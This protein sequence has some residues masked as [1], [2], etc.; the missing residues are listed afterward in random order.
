M[1]EELPLKR[2]KKIPPLPAIKL[3]SKR[4]GSHQPTANCSQSVYC[5][6]LRKQYPENNDIS[7]NVSCWNHLPLCWL[8]PIRMNAIVMPAM[9]RPK[10][11]IYRATAARA[12]Q[13][14]AATAPYWGVRQP[15]RRTGTARMKNIVHFV[16]CPSGHAH[17]ISW[18]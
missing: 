11:A 6:H 9:N 15:G 13:A 12:H 8:L 2:I 14:G 5:Y 10:I 3:C 18:L 7:M 17:A 16:R 4:L 1:R